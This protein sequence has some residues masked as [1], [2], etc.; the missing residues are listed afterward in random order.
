VN[1]SALMFGLLFVVL[2]GAFLLDDLGVLAVRIGL[3]LP[4]L[5]IVAGLALTASAVGG[6]AALMN[7]RLVIGAGLVAIG[8]VWL[9]NS[10]GLLQVTIPVIPVLLVVLGAVILL[11]A[12][13][14]RSTMNADAV[15][16]SQL[17]LDG[18]VRG[19]GSCSTTAP[20]P[21]ASDRVDTKACCTRATSS[22][23]SDRTCVVRVSMLDVTL[24]PAFEDSWLR[25]R[26]PV[27]WD[28]Q[29]APDVAI[30]LEIR[31]GASGWRST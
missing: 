9:A 1:R 28:V 17:Q 5:L 23:G 24:Q 14:S 4:A 11:T 6:T 18:A 30:E 13:T 29:L 31:T 22:E 3:L 8:A 21:C 15:E 2:G 20:A 25:R 26:S 16:E 12:L 19:R 27:N 7:G 10:L